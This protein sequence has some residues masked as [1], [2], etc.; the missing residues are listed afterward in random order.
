MAVIKTTGKLVINHELVSDAA[1]GALAAKTAI[2]I[3]TAYNGITGTF[4]LKKVR[5]WLQIHGVSNQQGPILIGVANGN[6]SA[7]EITTVMNE[8]NTAGPSDQT[9]VLTEDNVWV[10]FQN[11]IVMNQGNDANYSSTHV[12]REV[13]LGKGIPCL[14]GSGWQLFAFNA[15][16]NP[17]STG[18]T[19][20]GLVQYWGVWISD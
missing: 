6:A 7:A 9:Q 3:G 12:D 11:S 16:S 17:L 8:G 18:G 5:Y 13:S 1:L 2:A 15:D 20:Q 4:L 14:E 10:P 19:V